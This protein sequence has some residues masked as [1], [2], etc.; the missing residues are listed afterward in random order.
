[1]KRVSGWWLPDSDTHFRTILEGSRGNYIE[2]HLLKSLEFVQSWEVAVD[3]GAHIGICSKILSRKFKRVHAF[4]PA[5]DTFECLWENLGSYPNIAFYR[6][7]LGEGEREV[8]MEDDISKPTRVGN[9][10]ARFIQEG[11]DIRMCTLDS[12]KLEKVGFLKVD[13]E[14]YELHVLEGGRDTLLRCEPVVMIEI[15]KS[16]EDR[17]GLE[18]LAPVRFLEGLGMKEMLRVKPD[19]IF[20]F[21]G[22]GGSGGGGEKASDLHRL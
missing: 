7:A 17:Y 9:T 6:A 1:M 4:E 19:H 10:G 8:H 18:A 22:G 12:W 21:P 15:G 11:G 14:G 2:E 20:I 13:V 3:V 16:P 5:R